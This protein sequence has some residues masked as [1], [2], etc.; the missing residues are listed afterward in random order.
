MYVVSGISVIHFGHIRPGMDMGDEAG[1][2]EQ[3]ELS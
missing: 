1:A 3:H 2:G